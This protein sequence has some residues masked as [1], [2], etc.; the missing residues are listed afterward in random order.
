MMET[1]QAS[2][3]NYFQAKVFS[4]KIEEYFYQVFHQNSKLKIFAQSYLSVAE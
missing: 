2:K 1:K 3:E 4:R